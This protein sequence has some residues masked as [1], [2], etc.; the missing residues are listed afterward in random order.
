MLLVVLLLV[1]LA[2]LASYALSRIS[3]SFGEQSQSGERLAAVAHVLE[4][5][6]SSAQRLPCPA[7]PEA[8][9]GDEKID[10]LD[11]ANCSFPEGTLPW[12]TIGLR[13]D[14][15]YDAWGRKISYRVYINGGNGS[16]TQPRGISMVECDLVENASVLGP[17]RTCNSNADMYQRNTSADDFLLNKG[18]SL[19]DLGVVHNDVA[20]VL[21]SHGPTG[22]GAYTASGARMDMP[23]GDERGNTRGTGAFTIKAFSDPDVAANTGPHFD[24]LLFY[25]RLSDLARVTNLAAR[26]W[27][28]GALLNPVTMAA[29]GLGTGDTNASTFTFFG[30]TFTA[31]GG[32]EPEF[33]NTAGGFE[34]IGVVGEG[35][36]F[37][38]NGEIIRIDFAQAAAR[39]AVTLNHFGYFTIFSKHREQAEVRFYNG[40]TAVGIGVVKQGCRADGALATFVVEPTIAGS[41]FTRV[42]V[43]GKNIFPTLIIFGFPIPI[44]SQFLISEI[45][46]CGPTVAACTT[47]LA[48]ASNTCTP[49]S[50]AA[51]FAPA[52]VNIGIA[53]TLTFTITNGTDNPAHGAM[54][55]TDTLP[56][57][58]VVA[59]PNGLAHTCGGAPTITANAGTTSIAVSGLSID[60]DVAACQIT[61]NVATTTPG[62]YRHASAAISGTANLTNS[63]TES[64]LT[65]QP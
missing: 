35:S 41:S 55:F 11:S 19:T 29:V 53:S 8:D 62:T 43:E 7:E 40:A 48:S 28:E 37:I 61:V 3:A 6:A 36:H 39:I 56:T 23:A 22:F 10:P 44:S 59:T 26:D 65:V 33:S 47:T 32:S 49:P 1:M 13:K 20:Y 46:A 58:L 34:G 51:A 24:D 27:P 45:A 15:S 4:Q 54:S 12:K 38:E 21:I 5:Y 9:T 2:L 52:T 16:L 17:N 18:L 63:V 31:L 60:N 42:E 64:I 50:L 25:R 14:D 57:G 30:N